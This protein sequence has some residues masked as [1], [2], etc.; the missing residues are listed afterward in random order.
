MSI[1][2]NVPVIWNIFTFCSKPKYH[3][4]V[5]VEFNGEEI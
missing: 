1:L 4:S 5:K 2:K 3:T